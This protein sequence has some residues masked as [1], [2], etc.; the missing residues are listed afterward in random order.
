[1]STTFIGKVIDNYR[2]IENLGIGGM[3]VVFK[4]VHIKLDKLFALKMIAPGLLMN[5]NFIKRFQTEAK[6]LARLEDPNIVRIY[7]FRS[8]DDQWFI[9]ME[10]V[11]GM[12]LLSRIKHEGVFNWREAF[13]I[14]K[15]VLSAIG[16]AHEN[17]IIHRDIKPNNILLGNEGSVKVTDFGLAKD[18]TTFSNTMT[19]ASGGTLY[20]MSPEHLKGFSYTDKRSDIYSIGMTLYE[21]LTGQVPFTDINSDFDLREAIV[22]KE[23][24][25]PTTINPE[26]PMAVENLV[27]RAIAKN[28][29]KRF[30]STDE[31]LS[32]ISA[33]EES[34][35][36]EIKKSRPVGKGTTSSETGDVSLSEDDKKPVEDSKSQTFFRRFSGLQK[37]IV[38]VPALLVLGL[39]VLTLLEGKF[40]FA[41]K[42]GPSPAKFRIDINSNPDNAIV[43]LDEDS[44]G[45]TPIKEY[46][47]ATG[48]YALRLEKQNFQRIDSSLS[49]EVGGP[50]QFAF[51]LSPAR[52][53]SKTSIRSETV[54]AAGSVSEKSDYNTS[55]TI[56]SSPDSA[57]VMVNGTILGN[58]PIRLKSVVPGRY[59][60]QIEKEGFNPYERDITI[61]SGQHPIWDIVLTSPGG[62]LV[63]LSEPAEATVKLDGETIEN[64]QTPLLLTDVKSGKHRIEIMREGYQTVSESFEMTPGETDTI[65]VEMNKLYTKLSIQIKP[66]GSIYLDGKLLRSST[67]L[68]FE[69]ELPVKKYL[70][71]VTHPTMGVWERE[72]LLDS[73]APT[74]LL[75]DFNKRL[76]LQINAF[77]QDG[78]PLSA[79]IFL[80]QQPTNL[81]TPAELLLRIG[82]HQISINKNGYQVENN[83]VPVFVEEGSLEPVTFILKKIEN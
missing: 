4:A 80:D 76:N 75:I 62:S 58:T 42:S 10:Y 11:D 64:K 2:I 26:I 68:K 56:N 38:L 39:L 34:E 53:G 48:N 69:T 8:Y 77:D 25:R 49:I 18:Q 81:F 37:I 63:V 32:A 72:V 22:R 14:I 43:Y 51:R 61:E 82:N 73:Q 5:E 79:E 44:I 24:P 12:N 74:E 60:V 78:S 54:P 46:A 70:V 36:G 21:M 31:M 29:D 9:V 6:A 19:I 41:G 66:W 20:Y 13:T 16:H 71:K 17:D 15:K 40:P 30:Q 55:L 27:Q 33:I 23:M 67:D 65:S 47:L 59:Q 3:G 7:D 28:P 50:Q 45:V 83:N 1:M 35:K 52:K 57:K